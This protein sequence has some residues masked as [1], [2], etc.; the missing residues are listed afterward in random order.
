MRITIV[1][2]LFLLLSLCC[3]N[4]ISAQYFEKLY[5][6]NADIVELETDS[7]GTIWAGVYDLKAEWENRFDDIGLFCSKDNGYNWTRFDLGQDPLRITSIAFDKNNIVYVGARQGLFKSDNTYSKW[8]KTNFPGT[9]VETIAFNS[10]NDIFVGTIYE[11]IFKSKDGENQWELILD[12]SYQYDHRVWEL[13]IDKNDNILAGTNCGLSRSSDN[14]LTWEFIESFDCG[15]ITCLAE[16]PDGIIYMGGADRFSGLYRSNDGGLSWQSIFSEYE[17]IGFETYDIKISSIGEIYISTIGN[18]IS[19]IFNASCYAD[20]LWEYV[21]SNLSFP[22]VSRFLTFNANNELLATRGD[23][24]YKLKDLDTVFITRNYYHQLYQ[25]YPNPFNN[26]SIIKY[27]LAENAQVV[28][29]V[30]NMLGEEISFLVNKN[31]SPGDYEI[32]FNGEG[33]TSGVYIYQI[34]TKSNDAKFTEKYIETKKM[35]LIK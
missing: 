31:Q 32:E 4:N 29:K 26:S 33:L 27:S 17:N 28:L 12:D 2:K 34:V 14:G 10:S 11:G 7:Y 24:L 5:Q 15:D 35:I 22:A 6:F 13:L 30:F 21:G 18:N 23:E 19:G 3:F 16:S 8:V 25:N 1:L 20:T 9:D